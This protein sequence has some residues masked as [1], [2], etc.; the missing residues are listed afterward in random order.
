MVSGIVTIRL[1]DLI[2]NQHAD[3]DSGPSLQYGNEL[4]SL[5][6]SFRITVGLLILQA[7]GHSFELLDG[8]CDGREKPDN[9]NCEP[10]LLFL[11]TY[12]FSSDGGRKHN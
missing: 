4:V 2:W 1:R 10:T 5:N 7:V 8:V 11:M 6:Q 12:W 9:N 3:P